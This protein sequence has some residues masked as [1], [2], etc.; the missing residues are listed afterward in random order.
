MRNKLLILSSIIGLHL[1]PAVLAGDLGINVL[2][3]G[4]VAPGVYGQVEIG[5]APRPVLVYAQPMVI[6]VDKRYA[7]AQPVY[8]HVPPGH[9]KHWSKHCAEYHACG[10]Q[11]Y[12]VKSREYE[13]E[14]RSERDD[15]EHKEHKGDQGRGNG[16]GHNNKHDN[17]KS[18]H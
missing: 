10:R 4:E 15:R 11:V 3:A 2:L 13:P 7:R 18:K 5:N 12:F 14:Y 6:A 16:K 17:G 9:A 8:L 1:S